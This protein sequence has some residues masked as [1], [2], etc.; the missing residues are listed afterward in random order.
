MVAPGD[1]QTESFEV[2]RC[3]TGG[4]AV[5][6]ELPRTQK[7]RVAVEKAGGVQ[8]RGGS[9]VDPTTA[10]QVVLHPILK[11]ERPAKVQLCGCV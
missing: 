1:G 5:M 3:G 6:E 10:Q 4:P 7:G 2:A 9:R 8:R 11:P